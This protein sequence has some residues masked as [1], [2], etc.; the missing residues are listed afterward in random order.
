LGSPTPSP[1]ARR[2]TN[3]GQRILNRPQTGQLS[4]R[5]AQGRHHH[6]RLPQTRPTSPTATHHHRHPWGP[7]AAHTYGQDRIRTTAPM[8]VPT[9]R[10]N[11]RA[12]VGPP[13]IDHER[14]LE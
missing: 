8:R 3:S 11:S 2:Y 14:L 9:L 5:C 13:H 4:D 12:F 10:A 7:T 1:L 6:K